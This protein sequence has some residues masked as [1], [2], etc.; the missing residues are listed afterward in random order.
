MTTLLVLDGHAQDMLSTFT[1][2]KGQLYSRAVSE[3]YRTMVLAPGGK[4]DAEVLL[5][6]FLGMMLEACLINECCERCCALGDT[7]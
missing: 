6:D 3:R 2:A 1:S 5:R 7:G 4:V